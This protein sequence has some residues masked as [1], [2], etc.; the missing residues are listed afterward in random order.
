MSSSEYIFQKAKDDSE[1]ERLQLLESIFVPN[2]RQQFA[3]I[4]DLTGKHCLE[5]GAG[6][7]SVMRWL[8]EQVGDH[9]KI[10]AVDLNDRFLHNPPGNVELMIGDI[11]KMELPPQSF[12]VIHVRYVLIHLP[13]GV[14]LIEKLWKL[15]KPGGHLIIEEPDFR[16]RDSIVTTVK[17]ALLGFRNIHMAC[18]WMFQSNGM[19]CKFGTHM[20]SW[21]QELM[22]QTIEV[23]N[24]CPA[25]PGGSD[26]A[27]LMNL[28]AQQLKQAYLDTGKVTE[29]DFDLYRQFTE[30]PHSWAIY[31]ATIGVVA[32]R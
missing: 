15:L 10:T 3:T 7:G 25:V 26:L 21:V 1:L 6:A 17:D 13:D 28:S 32:Q 31:Y 24:Y 18:D 2:T 23:H 14:C 27:K 20:I 9:G 16:I 29:E 30:D 8:A 5:V 22:P 11:Q 12:D 19:D 4:G